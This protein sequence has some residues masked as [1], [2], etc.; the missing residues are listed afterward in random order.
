MVFG[1][2]IQRSVPDA[3]D[4]GHAISDQVLKSF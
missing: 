2:E 1:F 4:T 3:Q